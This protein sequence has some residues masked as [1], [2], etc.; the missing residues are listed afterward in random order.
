MDYIIANPMPFGDTFYLDAKVL[1][2]P[3]LF[4]EFNGAD[5]TPLDIQGGYGIEIN[6][7]VHIDG[8]GKQ[9]TI[10]WQRFDYNCQFQVAIYIYADQFKDK[11]LDSLLINISFDESTYATFTGGKQREV[12]QLLAVFECI[13]R[14]SENQKAEIVRVLVDFQL[15]HSSDDALAALAYFSSFADAA[16]PLIQQNPNL[17]PLVQFAISEFCGG[18]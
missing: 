13:H 5:M 9:E 4:N 17:L 16:R 15:F 18:S 10:A 2:H 3:K 8:D 12:Q 1:S 14:L 6:E 7:N 11:L